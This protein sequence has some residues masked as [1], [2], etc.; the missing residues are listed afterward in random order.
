MH[1]V[2]TIYKRE[3]IAFTKDN[4]HCHSSHNHHPK[5]TSKLHDIRASD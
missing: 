2:N 4:I 1:K 3:V 5:V